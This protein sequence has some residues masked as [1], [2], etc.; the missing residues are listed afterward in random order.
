[1]INNFLLIEELLMINNFLNSPS[2][3]KGTKG[4]NKE[5]KGS[6]LQADVKP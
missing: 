2:K 5:V 3:K 1:M 4:K 6:K